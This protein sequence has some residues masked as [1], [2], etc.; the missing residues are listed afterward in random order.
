MRKSSSRYIQLESIPLKTLFKGIDGDC[1][2][3]LP[4]G[5]AKS[6]ITKASARIASAAKSYATRHQ[7]KCEI[8]TVFLFHPNKERFTTEIALRIILVNNR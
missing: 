3:Y 1:G 8:Q 5:N 2:L 6:E 7:R 4:A